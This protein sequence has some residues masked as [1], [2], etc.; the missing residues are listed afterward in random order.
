LCCGNPNPQAKL[1]QII[2]ITWG[3]VCSASICVHCR[4]QKRNLRVHRQDRIVI[5]FLSRKWCCS[6][7]H[8]SLSEYVI[9]QRAKTG[10]RDR[11]VAST[12]RLDPSVHHCHDVASGTRR[13]WVQSSRQ[14][15]HNRFRG[16]ESISAA[17]RGEVE[18]QGHDGSL[19]DTETDSRAC[20]PVLS[21]CRRP[22]ASPAAIGT[23]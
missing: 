11:A 9:R 20:G 21:Q 5:T 4:G 2:T 14:P 15:G 12:G 6:Q 18:A 17:G 13:S 3:S 16:R 8:G 1:K 10:S 22:Q 23:N 7:K 19:G